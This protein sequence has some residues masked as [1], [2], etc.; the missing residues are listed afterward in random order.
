MEIYKAFSLDEL[1]ALVHK[2][3]VTYLTTKSMHD[4]KVLV[5]STIELVRVSRIRYTTNKWQESIE[6]DTDVALDFLTSIL[7]GRKAENIQYRIKYLVQNRVGKTRKIFTFDSSEIDLTSEYE[8]SQY[9]DNSL[10]IEEIIVDST[11]N[12]PDDII[13]QIF[14]YIINPSKIKQYALTTTDSI[15]KYFILLKV[16]QIRRRLMTEKSRTLDLI[17]PKDKLN[18][19]LL[20]SG[21]FNTNPAI[22]VLLSLMKD[23]RSLL[24]FLVLF[25]GQTITLPTISSINKLL[26]DSSSVSSDINN[27]NLTVSSKE[28]LFDLV[29]NI[30]TD[31]KEVTLNKYLDKYISTLMN[32]SADIHQKMSE[33]VI[34]KIDHS[35]LNKVNETYNILNKELVLHNRLL[36]EIII[37][38]STISEIHSAIDKIKTR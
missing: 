26:E 15:K 24:Q 1:D 19:V 3:I 28:L 11:K 13:T 6:F 29:A 30:N 37:T 18:S 22:F 36:Q 31:T 25:E 5:S 33:K 14:Y 23:F 2:N 38:M 16:D 17:I 21:L 9:I 8:N 20:M 10:L 7:E 27:E 32:N 4:M 12:L 34:E 35:N